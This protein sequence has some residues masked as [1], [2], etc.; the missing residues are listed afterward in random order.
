MQNSRHNR[1][2]LLAGLTAAG[3]SLTVLPRFTAAQ[4]GTPVAEVKPIDHAALPLKQEGKLIVHA[5]QPLY[6]PWFIDNDPTTGK[7]L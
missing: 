6:E 7:G 1:R 4:D 5:D 2:S 3:L